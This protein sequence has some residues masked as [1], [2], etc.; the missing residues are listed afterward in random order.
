MEIIYQK[1][2]FYLPCNK[3]FAK[4]PYHLPNFW[5][6]VSFKMEYWVAV[7]LVCHKHD[8]AFMNTVVI[9]TTHVSVKFNIL[10]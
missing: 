10:K 2:C 3:N 6:G 7:L 9:H 4:L 5:D 1:W 8:L